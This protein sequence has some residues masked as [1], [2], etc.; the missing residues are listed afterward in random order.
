MLPPNVIFIMFNIPEYVIFHLNGR[1]K[2]KNAKGTNGI[3]SERSSYRLHTAYA[4]GSFAD[5]R[6]IV[7][8]FVSSIMIKKS[9]LMKFFQLLIISSSSLPKPDGF[10]SDR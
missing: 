4:F 6:N 10:S 2:V 5:L 3:F 8:S 9:S 1:N 7:P